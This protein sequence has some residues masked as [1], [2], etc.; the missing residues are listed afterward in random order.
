MLRKELR[1]LECPGCGKRFPTVLKQVK[2]CTRGCRLR[3]NGANWYKTKKADPVWKEIRS[4]VH[5]EWALQHPGILNATSHRM[6]AARRSAPGH[7]THK[8]WLS[9][10][11]Q[12]GWKCFHCGKD[13]TPET[14][15]KDH[16]QPLAKGGSNNVENL[17]PSCSPCNKVKGH[18]WPHF[19]ISTESTIPAG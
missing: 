1:W 4:A 11:D 13:L 7:H 2:F 16:Y 9:R 19:N 10:I 8:Q 3:A 17:V 14:I 12:L 18:R 6:R 15:T 5:R